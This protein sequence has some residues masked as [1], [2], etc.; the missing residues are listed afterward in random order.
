MIRLVR[1][2]AVLVLFLGICSPGAFSQD[3]MS[4]TWIGSADFGT[5]DLV[6]S[7]DGTGVEKVAYH[8]SEWTCGPTTVSGGVST[9]PSTPWAIQDDAFSITNSIGPENK[10][11]MTLSGGFESATLATGTWNAESYGEKCAGTWKASGPKAVPSEVLV[12]TDEPKARLTE[13]TGCPMSCSVNAHG[14]W[15]VVFGCEEEGQPVV[16]TQYEGFKEQFKDGGQRSA[17]KNNIFR[18]RAGENKRVRGA[19]LVLAQG[20]VGYEYLASEHEYRVALNV[21]QCVENDPELCITADATGDALGDDPVRCENS[22]SSSVE[23]D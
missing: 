21:R 4:E 23:V 17:L 13:E 16:I 20:T 5:F 12:D 19:D 10:Q 1:I 6:L 18:P 3:E 9:E 15:E 8:F 11:R 14:E 22:S 2:S 7:A